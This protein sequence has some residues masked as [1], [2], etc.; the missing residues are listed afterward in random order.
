M[1][2]LSSSATQ[3]TL[4]H[5]LFIDGCVTPVVLPYKIHCVLYTKVIYNFRFSRI[6]SGASLNL[7]LK[8]QVLFSVIRS[9]GGS[10][11]K[12]LMAN[13]LLRLW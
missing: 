11:G 8:V 2:S 10:S 5:T 4:I 3:L 7:Y 13:S 1:F 6:C 12:D 9:S